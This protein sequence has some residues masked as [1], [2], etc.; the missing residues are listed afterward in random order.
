M[1]RGGGRGGRGW[2]GGGR[3]R[4]GGA[5]NLPP[6]GLTFTDIQNLSREAS[7]LYPVCYWTTFLLN[8]LIDKIFVAT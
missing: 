2:R 1:S 4:F 7:A 6:M 3:G 8:R 5:S